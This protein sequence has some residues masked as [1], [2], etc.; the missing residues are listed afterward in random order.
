MMFASFILLAVCTIGVV[1]GALTPCGSANVASGCYCVAVGATECT[2][3]A[4]LAYLNQP[5]FNTGTPRFD[6]FQ[7][8]YTY[9]AVTGPGSVKSNTLAGNDIPTGFA[10]GTVFSCGGG[11]FSTT[12]GGAD[13]TDAIA[14]EA[15]EANSTTKVK[16][17]YVCSSNAATIEI[18]ASDPTSSGTLS[19]TNGTTMA[20]TANGMC[21]VAPAGAGGSTTTAAAG[22]SGG[23]T[24]TKKSGASTTV[25]SAAVGM[26]LAL[27]V[28]ALL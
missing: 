16:I 19:D 4:A 12:L 17:K 26:I 2:A 13:Y 18:G 1:R 11:L 7:Q 6:V 5:K 8:N 22:G 3:A 25:V 21:C 23:A 14:A 15:T 9:T 28:A 24:T 20:S 27:A 10:A